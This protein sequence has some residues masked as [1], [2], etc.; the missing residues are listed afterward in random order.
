LFWIALYVGVEIILLWKG[1]IKYKY[2]WSLGHSAAFDCL[3]F[4]FLRLHYKKPLM[5]LIISVPITIFLVW[6][7]EIPVSVPIEKR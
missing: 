1:N 5:A 6:F 7:F 3:M 2:G 4:P